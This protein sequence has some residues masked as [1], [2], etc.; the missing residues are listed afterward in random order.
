MRI[1]IQ[2]LKNHP[3]QAVPTILVTTD[4]RRY[5]F[6]AH[7]T[8]QRF[9]REHL[10]KFSRGSHIFFTQTTT[11]HIAGV[12]GLL[13]TLF[14]N[15][16]GLEV[17]LYGPKGIANF[18]YNSRFIMGYRL[19]VYS[20]LELGKEKKKFLGIKSMD[21]M[22]SMMKLP[23][24]NEIFRDPEAFFEEH[25]IK[26]PKDIN[27]AEE[28]VGK[29]GIYQDESFRIIP[30]ITNLEAS[31]GKTVL[32]YVCKSKKL[33]GKVL[34]QKATELGIPKNLIGKL[35]AEGSL[36]IDGKVILA[37]QLKEPDS[38]G[39]CFIIIDCPKIEHLVNLASN[40]DLGEL[41]EGKLN[42]KEHV[43]KTIIHLTPAEV[44]QNPKYVEFIHK[45]SPKVQ[46]I[47]TD[48]GLKDT[49]DATAIS[50][51]K[52][53]RHF[54]YTNLYN[55]FY[56][57]QFPKLQFFVPDSAKSLEEII[58]DLPSK[59]T[60]KMLSELTLA[61]IKNEGFATLKDVK[62]TAT[63]IES[64]LQNPAT[65]EEFSKTKAI[66]EKVTN[67][68]ADV[69]ELAMFTNS[70]PEIV[71]LGTGSMMPSLYRNV[72]GIYIRFPAN[73]NI[74]MAFDAGEGS[75][76]QLK[77]HYG[78][79][80]SETLLR[81]LRV[82]FITHIHADHHLG[83]L[84]F[85]KERAKRA[86]RGEEG[87]SD[88]VFV[89]VPPNFVPWLDR[90]RKEIDEFSCKLIYSQHLDPKDFQSF[91]EEV[92]KE[93][94][95][96]ADD[97]IGYDYYADPSQKEF[98]K[99]F[100][101]VSLANMKD[102]KNFLE[103]ELGIVN[104]ETIPVVHCP[105]S[106][107]GLIEHKDG[108]RVV[109][110]G[111]T[112]FSEGLIS[113]VSKAT[114]VIHEATFNDELREQAKMRNH[115]TDKEAIITGIKLNAWRTVLTHFSQRY[116][117]GGTLNKDIWATEPSEYIKYLDNNVVL[118]SDH[119]RFKLSELLFMPYVSQFIGKLVPDE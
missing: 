26:N 88:P 102:F 33:P 21:F 111:D 50:E 107:A 103:Q 64:I 55:K 68:S 113:R 83:L 75:W 9:V 114:V 81:Q 58:G 31:T 70:D 100:E 51:N 112:K 53:F 106:Y 5:F 67:E 62:E 63:K 91:D 105:Q 49:K 2:I 12:F 3:T 115:S 17:K 76:Y 104:F 94:A 61:P 8:L 52:G 69:K 87:F 46:H 78:L 22:D 119:M 59:S 60:G 80:L 77:N 74:G 56:P 15:K 95:L 14:E 18:L 43:L 108:W 110:S 25:Q 109:Y 35:M 41:Y 30:I 37:D 98:L 44:V 32:S 82:I 66:I 101:E 39:P 36:T 16:A 86:E 45:F 85:L 65:D 84:Q 13:L 42:E 6:N 90:Y 99:K 29:D 116:A 34:P 48:H 71:F 118:A 40:P 96:E 23:N 79:T 92:K 4:T 89:I 47:F 57:N 20:A 97:E 7:E 72:S 54:Y 73:N 38:P 93:E 24:Y 28:F 27:D 1:T 19:L 10:V 11:D 117:K